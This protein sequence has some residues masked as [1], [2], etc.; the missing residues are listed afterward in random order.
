MIVSLLLDPLTMQKQNLLMHDMDYQHPQQSN[1]NSFGEIHT[2]YWFQ[3][4]HKNLCKHEDDL[5]CPLIM[6]V[7]GVGLDVMQR[8]SLEPVTFTLGIFNRNA[9]NAELFWRVLGYIP[10]PEKHCNVKYDSYSNS[11]TLKKEHY[12]QLLNV[13]LSDLK[14]LQDEGGFRW[15]FQCGKTF[16]LKFPIMYVIGD[17]LGLDKLCNRKETYTPTKTFMTGCCRDCNSVYKHCHDPQFICKQL[18]PSYFSRLKEKVIRS[19]T[20]EP[21]KNK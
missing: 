11:A 18:K 13:I 2:G 3:N 8:Q 1:H 12:H 16:N 6:F 10:N 20:F 9:R 7:D 14:S 19:M 4:A 21:I 5:L 15:T 17:A